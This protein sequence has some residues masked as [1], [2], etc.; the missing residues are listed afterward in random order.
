MTE[1]QHTWHISGMHCPRC[2]TAVL[3]AVA[4]LPGIH[5][6]HADWQKGTLTADWDSEIL[7]E[8]TLSLH[9]SEAGY[10]LET[11]DYEKY[12]KLKRTILI[13]TA[14]AI[15]FAAMELTPLRAMLSAFPSAAVGMSLAALFV[16]G[17]TTSLHCVGM[18][19]GIN[20][21]QSAGAAKAGR[22]VTLPNLQ[23]NLG[24]ICSYTVTGG[25]AGTFGSV[26]R[27]STGAQS[28]IQ[29]FAAVF[30]LLMAL[31]LL[32]AGI[33]TM[34]LPE[35][36]RYR[37]TGKGKNSSLW[38]GLMN[39]LMPCGPLQAMQLYAIST[40]SW[41]MGALSMLVF[42]LGTVPLMLGFGWVSGRL[43]RRF[44]APVRRVSGAIVLVMSVAMLANGLAL[45][46]FQPGRAGKGT[47]AAVNQ[48]AG[49]Q[50]VYSEL[51]WRR[52]PDITVRAGMPVRWNVYAGEGRITGCNREMVI[53]ALN[54]RVP[55][56][57]GDNF[58]EF[59]ADTPGVIEYT[60]WMGML[61]GSITV[62][63]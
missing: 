2:E 45:A 51:D 16:L 54:L 28:G 9:I 38:I 46:G 8:I 50:E 53:P 58:I 61:H 22:G 19:G 29:I 52:Y 27:L 49:V 39:G 60:C 13:L 55:L 20:L 10:K 14:A 47:E 32:D 44:A 24:R 41:W 21:A 59:T 25:I 35:R 15:L 36:F 11:H 30:M 5:G 63:E 7:P 31:N 62:T 18:C 34:V 4:S 26:F 42:S 1:Q 56:Q 12:Q 33:F 57:E 48:S 17:L 23:Y 37:L 6:A 3:K 40:G 43:N